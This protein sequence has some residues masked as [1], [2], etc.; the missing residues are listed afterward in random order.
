VS[1][2]SCGI[3]LKKQKPIFSRAQVAHQLALFHAVDVFGE[4][5]P[6]LFNTLRKWLLEIPDSFDDQEKNRC[7]PLTPL[8]SPSR[9]YTYRMALWRSLCDC[10]DGCRSNFP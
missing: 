9:W 3:F 8:A 10:A 1:Y 4:R 6:A 5:K 2:I 7:V